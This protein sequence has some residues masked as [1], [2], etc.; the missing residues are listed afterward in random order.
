MFAISNNPNLLNMKKT[1]LLTLLVSFLSF[2][3]FSQDP[4]YG[5]RAGLNISNMD[6]EPDANFQNKHRNGFMIGFF[7]EFNLSQT[8]LL[9]P[10]IQ[11]SSEGAKA[12]D[13]RIDYIQ[14]PVLLKLKIGNKFHLGFGPQVGVKVHEYEDG[15]KNFSY[16]GVGGIEYKLSQQLFLDARYT[17]GFSNVLDDELAIEAKNTNIQFGFGFKF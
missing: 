12:E 11:W 15:F 17:Y 16:S 2:Y 3:G 7:G 5:V 1:L 9:G 4:K 6:F 14:V 10:E 13:L 8:I